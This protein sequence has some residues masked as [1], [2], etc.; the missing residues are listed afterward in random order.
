M[1]NFFLYFMAKINLTP[2]SWKFVNI[3]FDFLTKILIFD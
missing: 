3:Y 2:D 1:I